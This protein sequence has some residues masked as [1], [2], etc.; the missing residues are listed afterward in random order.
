MK[1][2][3]QL[4]A[5]LLLLGLC[6]SLTAC[7]KED[8]QSL[9][10]S[11][12]STAEDVKSQYISDLQSKLNTMEKVHIS[13]LNAAS[14]QETVTAFGELATIARSM[15]DLTPP[16]EVATLHEQY[17]I[18]AQA[19]ADYYEGSA[20]LIS[21]VLDGTLSENQSVSLAE[22]LAVNL[23]FSVDPEQDFI[24]EIKTILG[25]T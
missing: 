12:V 16:P 6:T 13:I 3:K 18:V 7:Q 1:I 15:G 17:V 10:T 23:A 14:D 8:A 25:I 5:S 2:Q 20:S 21:Q 4:M 19:L 11:T 22:D 9:P 24:G